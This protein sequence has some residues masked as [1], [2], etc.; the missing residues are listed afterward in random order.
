MPF[1]HSTLSLFN[2]LGN[3]AGDLSAAVTSLVFPAPCRLCAEASI[4]SGAQGID[5]WRFCPS[6][7]QSG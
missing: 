7:G 6:K 5:T 4:S 2:W 3:L 1:E